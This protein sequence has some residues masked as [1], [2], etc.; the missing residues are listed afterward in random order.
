MEDLVRK[1]QQ[2]D[3]AA[4]EQLLA[5]FRQPIYALAVTFLKDPARAEDAAQEAFVRI[6]SRLVTLKNPKRFKSWSL[7][8]TANYCRD[9]LR[10]KRPPTVSL[11]QAPEPVSPA[12]DE[13][14]EQLL[15]ALENLA[16]KLRRALLLRDVEGFNYEEI[17][18]IQEV[19]VGTVK[20]RIFEARRKLRK[21]MT[22][23][24]VRA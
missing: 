22:A 19:P 11:D 8:I 23:C 7:T 2:G 17:A 20:S 13:G 12:T 9:L 5:Q 6:F 14:N 4:V 15:A 24:S 1:A 16:P 21:W 10:Q 18:E 3:R